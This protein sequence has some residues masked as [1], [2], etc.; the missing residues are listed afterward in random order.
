MTIARGFGLVMVRLALA[1]VLRV[2]CVSGI[3]GLP[4]G[5][6]SGGRDGYGGPPP[7]APFE[8]DL[9]DVFGSDRIDVPRSLDRVRREIHSTD[10]PIRDLQERAANGS[11]ERIGRDAGIDDA[12]RW[13]RELERAL[14][15][16]ENQRMARELLER[17]RGGR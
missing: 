1:V 10:D 2:G 4:T 15:D 13:A 9:R 5:G 17:L 14:E 11:L 12:G 7:L 16:P 8:S 3:S 6:G